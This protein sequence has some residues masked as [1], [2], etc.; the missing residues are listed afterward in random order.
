MIGDAIEIIG[1]DGLEGDRRAKELAAN[2][3]ADAAR[4]PIASLMAIPF[5]D[6]IR[7]R[8]IWCGHRQRAT[9]ARFGLR[10][11]LYRAKHRRLPMQLSDVADDRRTAA[12]SPLFDGK[13]PG[14]VAY[15]DGY[16]LKFENEHWK[17]PTTYE[18]QVKYPESRIRR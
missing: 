14:Y 8:N 15:P 16:L 9:L 12:P 11:A 1:V 18:F 6:W 4:F 7:Y 10:I 5:S 2:Y 3:T 13:T 17:E